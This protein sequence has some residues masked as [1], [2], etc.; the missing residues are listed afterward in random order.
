MTS[1]YDQAS[2]PVGSRLD[3]RR[4]GFLRDL[5]GNEH[6]K[7]RLGEQMRRGKVP[8][9]SFIYGPTGSG[10]TTLARIMVRHRYCEN[11]I[12][13]GDPCG[14]CQRCRMRLRDNYKLEEWAGEWAEH[15]WKWWQ[16]HGQTVL[17]YDDY[18]IFMDEAQ[19]LSKIHQKWFL[20]QLEDA[21]ATVV[22]ATTHRN[23]IVDAL[24]A[25]FGSNVFEMRR[26]T[27]E[28][29][30]AHLEPLGRSLGLH[31]NHEQMHQVVNA[32]GCDMRLCVEFMHTAVDQAKDKIVT[33]AYL[34]AVLGPAPTE[35][36]L[37]NNAGTRIRL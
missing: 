35:S 20:K 2:C 25:R 1:D 4:P 19:D 31:M 23:E 5:L 11:R 36:G 7:L 21:Q 18:F 17:Q 13:I 24:Q 37:P 16:D 22:F 32:Y 15:A 34:D 14:K 8:R 9:L 27:E 33:Q 3:D 12:G 30:V 26:P 29:V 6:V 10:K 28:Q